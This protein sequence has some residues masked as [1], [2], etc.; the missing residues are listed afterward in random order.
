MLGCGLWAM[1]ATHSI[2]C[3]AQTLYEF[4]SDSA[5]VVFTNKGVSQHIPHLIREY[6]EAR[7]LH[8]QIWNGLPSQIPFMLLYDLS[9]DGNAGVSAVPHTF[10]QIYMAPMNKSYFTSANTEHF[11]FLFKH[12]YTHVVMHDK[13]NSKD[14]A[15]RKFTGNKV[16]PNANYPLSAFWSYMDAPRVFA[17]RWYQEGI[18]CFMETW[19]SGGAGR[20]LSGFDEAYFR[21]RV[22]DGA[23]LYS[24][25]G[26]ETEG[27]TADI[28]QGSTGYLY[29]TR[30]VNYLV[31]KYGYDKLIE[32]YNRTDSSRT[33]YVRQFEQ[34]YGKGLREVWKEW[35]EYEVAFQK[36][37]LDAIAEY[38]LTEFEKV[39][40]RNLG[41]MSPMIVDEENSVAYASVDHT[42]DFAQIVRVRLDSAGR[43]GKK[44][45]KIAL[46][47][48]SR[49]HHPAYIALDR[50][51][52]RLFWTDRN[53]KI[54][55]LVVYDLEKGRV[56]KKLKYKRLGDI[57]YDNVN[58]C[59]YGLMS[60]QGSILLVK[61]DPQ[62]ENVD[63]IY[64]FPFGTTV[65]DLDV[66]H[67]GK[68]LVASLLGNRGDHSL[69]MFDTEDIENAALAYRTLCS[70]DDSNLSQFR[71][72]ADDSKLVG[73]S[74]YTG[75][76]NIWSYDMESGELNLLTNVQTGVFA[77]YLA[78]DG[79]VY[80]LEYSSEGMTPVKF[81]YQEL[82]DANS[83][84]FLGQR[85][86]DAH[87]E[88]AEIKDLKT[89][90]PEITFSE[91]YDSI[92]VYKPFKAAR[93]QGIYPDISGFT[94]RQAWNNVTPVVG[95]HLSF[96]DPLSFFTANFFIGA[97]PWSHNEW[98]NRFHLSADISYL[99]WSLNASWNQ[100]DFYDLFGPRR[101][102]RKGYKVS[103][104]Y[105][106]KSTLQSPTIREWGA[107]VAHYGDMDALPL[108]QEIEVDEGITSFQ[109]ASLY[110]RG[111][112]L[113]GTLGAIDA[114]KG[115][116]YSASA[117]SYLA[118][119][120]LFPFI[121]VSAD[122]GFHLPVGNHNS[123]W[124]RGAAGQSFG[125]SN[126]TLGN[127]YFGGFRNNYVDH[128]SINRFRTSSSM[129]GF[130]IDQIEAHSYAKIGAEIVGAP[131]RLENVGALRF[132]PNFIQF[133]VFG[134]DLVTNGWEPGLETRSHYSAGAQM[135]IQMVMFTHMKTTLSIG[136][137][138]AW[139][140]NL[141]QGEFMV[142]LKLL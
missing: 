100:S 105:D 32:F 23:K 46:I 91:V 135:N 53:S 142:S 37:N 18:A 124:L 59:L 71:F 136:Y 70:F 9:D 4:K 10:I 65:S 97:S 38:P 113:F 121:D 22:K 16:V 79:T 19:L 98:K 5:Y 138:R 45:E 118:S 114:E 73:F 55:G 104:A 15:W 127:S 6:S 131:I 86:Y 28:E 93:F 25:V 39:V 40:D 109:T 56:E 61:Y 95:A 87:P 111:G 2:V 48:G 84:E 140:D 116:K 133:S 52:Q 122:W 8:N 51:R 126:S 60:N 49:S 102:S 72:S 64:S 41:S 24:V 112:K 36:E 106:F 89:E 14:Y 68:H 44:V 103:L 78:S 35:Q 47:E 81:P 115:Y 96:Y 75:V 43:R 67:D 110:Y 66:S 29:G 69:I 139:A 58:D 57:C 26:L 107:S 132:Y 34:V 31:L 88:I 33:S 17:P 76:P 77:P 27:S 83:V 54:R 12:E 108:Y 50:N 119:G 101:T 20:S 129:P 30:F 117:Y 120:K 3:S 11:D 92:K 128:A 137:A 13:S 130:R 42:G 123:F 90:L 94:D 80:A 141:K 62:I 99:R 7:A 125:D 82:H 74:Y 21:T 134:Y 1:L 85:A 63:I